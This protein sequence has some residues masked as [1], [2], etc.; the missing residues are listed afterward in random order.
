MST[1][2]AQFKRRIR[3]AIKSLDIYGYELNLTYKNSQKFKTTLGGIFTIMSR[4]LLFIYFGFL[5]RD[6]VNQK[7]E[8]KLSTNFRDL[9]YDLTEYQ[10]TNDT[11]DIAVYT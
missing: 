4:V 1:F 9:N 5:I 10:L 2:G 6:I 3:K 11:F 8:V 7:A